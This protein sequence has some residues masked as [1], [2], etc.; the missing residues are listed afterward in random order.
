[1]LNFIQTN[2]WFSAAIVGVLSLIIGSVLNIVICFYPA[3]IKQKK[4]KYYLFFL[5]QEKIK[6]EHAFIEKLNFINPKSH[7][8]FCKKIFRRLYD[9][10]MIGYLLFKGKCAYC[11]VRLGAFYPVVELLTAI[12]GII[13]FLHLGW[14]FETLY[15]LY[16]T[17][18]LI[19]IS[20]IDFKT[21]MV[22]NTFA[23]LLLW[24]GLLI[25]CFSIFATLTQAVLGVIIG[26]MVLSIFQKLFY[27]IFKNDMIGDGDLKLTAA[28]SAW[29]GIQFLPLL[30]LIASVIAL[31]IA[32]I[33]IGF[34][35]IKWKTVIAFSPFLS[36]S[37][38]LLLIFNTPFQRWW[39]LIL[40]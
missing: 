22:P 16:F 18:I 9:H 2:I 31:V 15:A 27:W 6:I 37:G 36:L 10:S 3:M 35:K 38:W 1:M 25:N 34:H 11:R 23:F 17:W 7:D 12:T 29:V 5:K 4:L 40:G 28:L 21:Q 32:I 39:Y 14:R 30:L 33:L 24:S 19:V 8:Y 20:M 13:V 26:Y